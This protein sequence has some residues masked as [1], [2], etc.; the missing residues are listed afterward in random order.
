MLC[1]RPRLLHTLGD[2]ICDYAAQYQHLPTVLCGGVFQNK[3]LLEYCLS[4]LSAQGNKVLS[5]KQIPINDG[6]I[7]LGQL[8]YGIH[9]SQ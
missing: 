3:Y 6:G 5:S 8:W 4:K 9:Q 1:H 7:A 2:A